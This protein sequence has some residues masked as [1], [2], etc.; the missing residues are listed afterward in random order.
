MKESYAYVILEKKTQRLRKETGNENL[1]SML[2]TGRSS[3]EHFRLSIIRPI[4]MLVLSPMV[5]T[6]SLFMATVRT[7]QPLAGGSTDPCLDLW[8]PLPTLHDVP[9]HLHRQLWLH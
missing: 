7:V 6:V 5:F 1:R 3:K 9:A 4:R 8:L 2:H